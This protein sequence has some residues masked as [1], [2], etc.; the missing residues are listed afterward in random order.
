MHTHTDAH[1]HARARTG[2]QNTHAHAGTYTCTCTVHV[3][4]CKFA[5]AQV[6]DAIE[7]AREVLRVQEPK[8]MQPKRAMKCKRNAD[9]GHLRAIPSTQS[10]TVT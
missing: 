4:M 6:R 7:D 5:H 3:R 8:R 1:A 2:T 9:K 10:H